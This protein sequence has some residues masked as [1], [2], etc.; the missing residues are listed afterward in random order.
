[1]EKG[2]QDVIRCFGLVIALCELR[3]DEAAFFGEVEGRVEKVASLF[4]TELS[5]LGRSILGYSTN[6]LNCTRKLLLP[7]LIAGSQS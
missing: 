3:D 1:M 2:A 5:H 7:H 4:T 6:I